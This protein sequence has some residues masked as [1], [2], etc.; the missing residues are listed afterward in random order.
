MR[1]DSFLYKIAED[2]HHRYGKDVRNLV[3][4]FP[5]RRSGRVFQR[6]LAQLSDSPIWS[7]MITT[8]DDFFREKSDLVLADP[9]TQ[10]NILHRVW[11]ETYQF[12]EPEP[13]Q[14]FYFF[15]KILIRDFDLVDKYLVSADRIYGQVRDI[16]EIDLSFQP[17]FE[18]HE[19]LKDLIE[20]LS[21]KH[22]EG[23][24]GQKFMKVWNKLSVLYHAFKKELSKKGL[25][26]S[27]MLY[28]EVAIR[29]EKM[30]IP[31][32]QHFI[33][34]GFNRINRCE[35]K[36][37]SLL[38]EGGKA[39]FYW[40]E[41]PF[42]LN[43]LKKEGGKFL[44]EN[45][46]LFP[47]AKKTSTDL[48]QEHKKLEI[49]P[50]PFRSLQAQTVIK[51]MVNTNPKETSGVVLSD[52]E[53]LLPLLWSLPENRPAINVSAG[54]KISVTFAYDLMRD[55]IELYD[56]AE[57]NNGEFYYSHLQKI[58][59]NPCFPGLQSK[60]LK[61]V[62]IYKEVDGKR[63]LVDLRA[64]VYFSPDQIN[65][66]LPHPLSELLS[67]TPSG[68]AELLEKMLKILELAY[69]MN[70]EENR[71]N[72]QETVNLTQEL[73]R[74]AHQLLIRL[75]DTLSEWPEHPDFQLLKNMLRDLAQSRRLPFKGEP[76]SGIQLMGALE[77]R[78]VSYDRLILPS[79]NEGIQPSNPGQTLIPFTLKKYYGL[80]TA[81]D[82]MADQSYY[83][84]TLIA[85]AKN[86][87][88]LYDNSSGGGLNKAEPSRFIQQIKYGNFTNW[89]FTS[90]TQLS[91]PLENNQSGEIS[92]KRT[93]E[94]QNQLLKQLKDR[95]LS[96]SSFLNFLKCELKFYF[97]FVIGAGTE[98]EIAEEVDARIS[99]SIL[100]D[101][102]E[103]LYKPYENK[104]VA[105]REIEEM[106][107]KLP[108]ELRKK[109]DKYRKTK[110]KEIP[111]HDL[112]AIN[113]L[114]K[115]AKNAL[116]FDS[117]NTPFTMRG[118]EKKL[119]F[120]KEIKGQEVKFTAKVDRIH[121]KNGSKIIVDYKTGGDNP[122]FKPENV[123]PLPGNEQEKPY[124]LNSAA[125]QLFLYCWML[126]QQEEDYRTS[127]LH[128]AV[129]ATRKF[130]ESFD[131]YLGIDNGKDKPKTRIDTSS[132]L[133]KNFTEQFENT[134]EALL[135]PNR[136]FDQTSDEKVCNYCEF[137]NIC[138][139]EGKSW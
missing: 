77:S 114:T 42:L 124:Q 89:D 49:I 13:F 127:V 24:P 10:L 82:E 136:T 99:G 6:H 28:K 73:I 102:M 93:T 95:G 1:K 104:E 126:Q 38:K 33:F 86:L 112:V 139:R 16:K 40:N 54:I 88:I 61:A 79:M 63:K 113:Y 71:D 26:Y 29:L 67:H 37:F 121:E 9:L 80:P 34:A 50:L 110:G 103:E 119:K 83:F 3:L 14:Q 46:Q 76:L 66:I 45:L 62:K 5:N 35:K 56:E 17:D 106:K 117:R 78:N 101:L 12:E 109:L 70:T 7:P 116:D 100:H 132:E 115:I 85:G 122:E 36:L 84:W 15:G 68:S 57:L 107:T 51:L 4:V 18:E 118:H 129:Y 105:T 43:E 64:D 87:T 41:D 48:V 138:M 2:V 21:K 134:L 75:K 96:P 135:N 47:P 27:G 69:E 55:L 65:T 8:I 52:E 11:N 59:F 120:T 53:M 60:W 125:I 137:K 30:S 123:M 94:I 97:N 90:E 98:E 25:A 128:P 44:S 20:Y 130:S 23:S 131:P 92:I 74:S 133:Y 58:F 108:L 31:E 91:L 111:G 39:D 22:D 72:D 19:A 32:E 81:E